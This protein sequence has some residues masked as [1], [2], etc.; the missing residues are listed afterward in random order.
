MA[1]TTAPPRHYLSYRDEYSRGAMRAMG[2]ERRSDPVFPDLVFSFP[3]PAGSCG[4]PGS[5][6]VGVM[7]YWGTLPT[8]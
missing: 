8:V 1:L 4:S 7:A 3:A 5:V 6:A 2:V